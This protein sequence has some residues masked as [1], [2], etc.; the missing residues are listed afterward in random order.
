MRSGSGAC[1]PCGGL[2]FFCF[3][4]AGDLYGLRSKAGMRSGSGACLPCGGLLFVS[5]YR[6]WHI[7]VFV[8]LY[9]MFFAC[10]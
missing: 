4:L 1:L 10:F 5:F 3:L 2:W 7:L 6:L 8:C 9:L